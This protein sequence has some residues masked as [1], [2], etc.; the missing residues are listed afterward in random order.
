MT[1]SNERNKP[2]PPGDPLEGRRPWI[3]LDEAQIEEDPERSGQY[4]VTISGHNLKM[5]ISPPRISVGGV[6]LENLS[7]DPGGKHI[8]G[9]LPKKPESDEVTVDY[10]FAK[11]QTKV[12]QREI[13]P[14]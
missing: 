7:F 8:T 2:R 9:T 13:S 12:A 11:G 3:R 4:R 10:G 6:E 5:A 1:T 14:D